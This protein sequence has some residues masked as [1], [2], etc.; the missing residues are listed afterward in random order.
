[1]T[2]NTNT[3]QRVSSPIHTLETRGETLVALS[4]LMN[5]SPLKLF[6]D[7]CA[8]A[9]ALIRLRSSGTGPSAA[10]IKTKFD[11]YAVGVV[12]MFGTRGRSN[13][14]RTRSPFACLLHNDSVQRG[15]ILSVSP[16]T[17]QMHFSPC[18]GA[19]TFSRNVD[20]MIRFVCLFTCAQLCER[21]QSTSRTRYIVFG[22]SRLM[23]ELYDVICEPLPAG[24]RV[25]P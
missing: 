2:T 1:M 4:I 20:C 9:R 11:K 10:K 14:S 6:R 5:H 3:V 8:V 15:R 17:L 24:T 7:K 23:Q 18:K 25:S 19:C 21:H 12:H 16:T 22:P 13:S